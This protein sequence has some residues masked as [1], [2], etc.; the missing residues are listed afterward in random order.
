MKARSL[1]LIALA[2]LAGCITIPVPVNAARLLHMDSPN[3]IP[4]AYK[5]IFKS[6]EELD[7]IP[8]NALAPLAILPNVTPVTR[9]WTI[10]LANALAHA[11]NVA[12]THTFY[13]AGLTGFGIDGIA[14][15][16]IPDVLLS[17]PRIDYIEP[18]MRLSWAG[19][20]Q[21]TQSWLLD[22]IDQRNLPTDG[23]YSYTFLHD[24]TGGFGS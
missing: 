6:K 20:P 11:G 24:H 19:S 18:A 2:S 14:D 16:V 15:G 9:V 3:R 8:L 13:G 23:L 21:S 1:W 12:V 17:D 4:G 22:R 5:V 7:S 10:Q